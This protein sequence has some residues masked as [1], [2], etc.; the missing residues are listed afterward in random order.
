MLAVKFEKASII[1]PVVNETFSLVE[2]VQ[3][4][5]DTSKEDILEIIIVVADFTSTDSFKTIQE[6]QTLHGNLVQVHHQKMR[7]IGGAMREAFELAKGSHTI[8]MASDLETDPKLVP[9]LISQA[10]LFPKKII[11]VTR[12][13]R[14]GGFADYSNIKLVANWLF[15][16]IFSLLYCTK[17]TDMT[18]AYRI[19]PTEILKSIEW[20]ELRHP[21]LFE[22]II[23]PLRMGVEAI[24]IPGFWRARTEGESQNTF[25]RNFEYFKIGLKVRFMPKSKIIKASASN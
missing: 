8:M 21:F 25:F 24:E 12:W 9:T 6:L 10:K 20:Q 11:T 17:L 4:I 1:L 7:F 3:V 22:T 2:T 13:A 16:K 19:F 23:K 14:G 5:M 15:Q 18:Y